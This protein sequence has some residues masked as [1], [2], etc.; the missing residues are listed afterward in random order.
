MSKQ[1]EEVSVS[2]SSGGVTI[3]SDVAFIRQAVID[4]SSEKQIALLPDD[5]GLLEDIFVMAGVN[6]KIISDRFLK[7]GDFDLYDVVILGTG[8]FKEYK[9]L[10]LAYNK[11]K[12]YMEQGGNI[13]AF[14]QPDEWRDDLLPVSLISTA[15]SVDNSE[16]TN[17]QPGHTL[18]KNK[19][20]IN[21][22]NLLENVSGGYIAYPAIVFPCEKIIGAGGNSSL[23]ATAQFGKGKFIYCGIPLTE[24]ISNLELEAIDFLSNLIKYTDR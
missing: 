2:L 17:S 1:R 9:S 18:F 15:R 19:R 4:I 6:Y 22:S 16:L 7:T 14:G 8:C 23:L 10:E 3:A 20:N 21:V 11:F 24:L 5:L 13:I 12:K